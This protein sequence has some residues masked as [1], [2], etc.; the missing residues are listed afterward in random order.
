[1]RYVSIFELVIKV[2]TGDP[3]AYDGYTPEKAQLTPGKNLLVPGALPQEDPPHNINDHS[4]RILD[5]VNV[6]KLFLFLI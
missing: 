3:N 4:N 1:V 2:I 5:N 6:L